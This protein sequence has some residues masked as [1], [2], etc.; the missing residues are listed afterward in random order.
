MPR[1]YRTIVSL[2]N[3][4]DCDI[5]TRGFSDGFHEGTVPFIVM[6]YPENIN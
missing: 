5:E 2:L 1:S 6:D 3:D 4:L